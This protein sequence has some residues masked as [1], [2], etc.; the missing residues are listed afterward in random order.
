MKG[1]GNDEE[2][3]GAAT[4]AAT[5]ENGADDKAGEETSPVDYAAELAS[6]D[7]TMFVEQCTNTVQSY[8]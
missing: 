6:R 1:K 5:Q 3:K 2:T 4:Q 7:A 8:L